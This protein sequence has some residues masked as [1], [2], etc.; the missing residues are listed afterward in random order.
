MRVTRG[1]RPAKRLM[2]VKAIE[3]NNLALRVACACVRTVHGL[4]LSLCLCACV[5]VG[6]EGRLAAGDWPSKATWTVY[7]AS[8]MMTRKSA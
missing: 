1:S 7:G 8:F 5:T 2:H 4:F 3:R 6:G